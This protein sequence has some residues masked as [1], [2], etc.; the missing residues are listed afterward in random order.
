MY[1]DPRNRRKKLPTCDPEKY[2]S[3]R[4]QDRRHRRNTPLSRCRSTRHSP[5]TGRAAACRRTSSWREERAVRV[6]DGGQWRHKMKTEA[7][8]CADSTR[9]SGSVSWSSGTLLLLALAFTPVHYTYSFLEII[10][11]SR[12][13]SLDQDR[14]QQ[15]EQPGQQRCH[16]HGSVAAIAGAGVDAAAIFVHISLALDVLAVVAM[17]SRRTEAPRP[18]LPWKRAAC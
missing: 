6:S 5:P 9:A 12:H 11:C 4:V 10:L 17:V 15:Q 7:V 8:A 13:R 14:R 3:H 18:D 2:R 1:K 16:C